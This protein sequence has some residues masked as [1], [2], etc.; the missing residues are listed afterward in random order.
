MTYFIGHLLCILIFLSEGFGRW[1]VGMPGNE[2]YKTEIGGRK[3]AE[4]LAH[5]ADLGIKS[6]LALPIK[7]N[8]FIDQKAV[9]NCVWAQ[10]EQYAGTV[11]CNSSLEES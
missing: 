2:R 4:N 8:K 5:L 7:F 1:E 6:F 9:T 3:S 10:G 11:S